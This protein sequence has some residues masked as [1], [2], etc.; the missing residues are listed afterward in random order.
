MKKP[1][2]LI[3]ALFGKS[4]AFPAPFQGG[5]FPGFCRHFFRIC[6]TFPNGQKKLNQQAVGKSLVA[7]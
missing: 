6:L 5:N 4:G 7:Q 2:Y 3:G 1:F